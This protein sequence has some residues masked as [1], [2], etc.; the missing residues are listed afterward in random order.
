MLPNPHLILA[1]LALGA[2]LATG[3]PLYADVPGAAAEATA[4]TP[5][6]TATQSGKGTITT[7]ADDGST[8]ELRITDAQGKN[9]MTLVLTI[10][11]ATKITRNKASA[12][13]ADLKPGDSVSFTETPGSDPSAGTALT[14]SAK[15]TK[16]SK[17]GQTTGN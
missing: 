9:A 5:A 13:V 2:L 4:D 8:V 16:V 10:T 14:I 1:V 7:V 12:K 6:P 17:T 11:P 15:K 3:R